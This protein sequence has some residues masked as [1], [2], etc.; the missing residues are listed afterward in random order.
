MGAKGFTPVPT[1]DNNLRGESAVKNATAITGRIEYS[2][3]SVFPV[4]K[5]IAVAPVD[6]KFFAI[7]EHLTFKVGAR[8]YTDQRGIYVYLDGEKTPTP[9]HFSGCFRGRPAVSNSGDDDFLDQLLVQ[10]KTFVKS[11]FT[12]EGV[13]VFKESP[14]PCTDFDDDKS[15]N[16]LRMSRTAND[17]DVIS[18]LAGGKWEVSHMVIAESRAFRKGLP[19]RQIFINIPIFK[20]IGNWDGEE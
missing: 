11:G 15:I 14:V 10:K 19:P 16:Y 13:R 12:G 18:A 3:Y 17:W 1:G 20:R 2:P 9:V 7:N 6:S 5:V 8:E 4:G